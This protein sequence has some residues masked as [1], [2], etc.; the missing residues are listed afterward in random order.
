M[1]GSSEDAQVQ[2]ERLKYNAVPQEEE[3][4]FLMP[5]F[6]RIETHIRAI[7]QRD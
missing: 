7:F 2:F 1:S 3:R 4:N 5:P 6:I